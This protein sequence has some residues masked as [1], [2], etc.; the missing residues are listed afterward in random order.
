SPCFDLAW[1]AA[2]ESIRGASGALD[3]SRPYGLG[4]RHVFSAPASP[5]RRRT[6]PVSIF[7]KCL[8]WPFAGNIVRKH[9]LFARWPSAW[10]TDTGLLRHCLGSSSLRPRSPLL[11]RRQSYS[12]SFRP[13]AT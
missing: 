7:N 9:G 4:K 10:R 1:L 2:L 13:L 11:C 12:P 8:G 5:P 3:L 6:G